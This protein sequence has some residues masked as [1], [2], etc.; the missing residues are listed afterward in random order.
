MEDFRTMDYRIE[1]LTLK[2]LEIKNNKYITTNDTKFVKNNYDL[3]YNI[4][5][6]FN[7]FCLF[8]IIL[9]LSLGYFKVLF[10]CIL[11]QGFSLGYALIV[12]RALKVEKEIEELIKNRIF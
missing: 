6:I 11:L 3:H 1:V 2:S 9:L 10:V 5:F 4:W 12:L 7:I 8:A